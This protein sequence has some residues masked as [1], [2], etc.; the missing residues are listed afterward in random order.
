MVFFLTPFLVPAARSRSRLYNSK[1]IS[2]NR[3]SLNIKLGF[4]IFGLAFWRCLMK[5]WLSKNSEVPVRVQLTE[6]IVLGIASGDLKPEEKLPSTRELARRFNIHQNTVSAVY[7]SLAEQ[8]LVV[9][10]KGSGVFVAKDGQ[11]EGARPRLHD[12]FAKF[13]RGAKAAGFSDREVEAHINRTMRRER[14]A[15]ILVVESDVALREI[16][17]DEIHDS[18]S[19]LTTGMSLESFAERH[20]NLDALIVAMSD[21]RSKLEP[22][23]PTGT[24]CVFLNANSVPDA[25]SGRQRPRRDELIAVVSG[26]ERFLAL[27]QIYLLAA[28]VEPEMILSRQTDQKHWRKAV[29]QAALIICDALTAKGFADDDPRVRTF[30]LVSAD[31][32]EQIKVATSN[33]P[34]AYLR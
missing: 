4:F 11:N 28:K 18:T 10:R 34:T 2:F 24:E 16:I 15:R 27:A 29:D 6:Q 9:N 14:P 7:R 3:P 21:E 31:S 30:M 33:L 1:R 32:I 26:W 13:V 19:L 23:L 5:F 12:L 20:A 17:I 22:I 8:G 25:L